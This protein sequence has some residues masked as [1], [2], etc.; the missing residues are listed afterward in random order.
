MCACVYDCVGDHVLELRLKISGG[1]SMNQSFSGSYFIFIIAE[2]ATNT[3]R[4]ECLRFVPTSMG[5]LKRYQIY[6]EHIII[7]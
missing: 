3:V 4:T 1:Y 6:G 2:L 5:F 7:I